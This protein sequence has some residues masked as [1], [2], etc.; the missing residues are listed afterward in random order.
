[1]K[2]LQCGLTLPPK[3]LAGGRNLAPKSP[4]NQK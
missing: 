3:D 2:V 4:A 1:V